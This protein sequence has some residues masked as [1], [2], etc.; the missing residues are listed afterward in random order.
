MGQTTYARIPWP[1]PNAFL[2]QANLHMRS[3]AESLDQRWAGAALV[4]SV[5]MMC[6]TGTPVAFAWSGSV[7]NPAVGGAVTAAADGIT[8]PVDGIY[9]V[10]AVAHWNSNGTG[11]RNLQLLADGGL[12]ASDQ[13]DSRPSAGA[14]IRTVNQFTRAYRLTGG[15]KLN[16]QATQTS[17]VTLAVIWGRLDVYRI[18]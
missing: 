15:Q 2:G 1:E 9:Q 6:A 18:A 4:R 3:I 14:S 8:V 10:N 17:G 13:P 12:I 11:A 7:N 16:L 5:D